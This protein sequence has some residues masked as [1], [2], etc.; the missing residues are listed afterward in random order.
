MR[1]RKGTNVLIDAFNELSKTNDN[2]E[3]YLVGSIDKV[4]KKY[5]V[6]NQNECIKIM[7]HVDQSTL[8]KYYQKCDIFVLPSFTEGLAM[9]QVQALACGLPIIISRFTGGDDLLEGYKKLGYKKPGYVIEEVSKEKIK[10]AILKYYTNLDLLSHHSKIASSLSKKNLSWEDYG[11][12][13]AENIKRT[14]K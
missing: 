2:L 10:E 14:L 6:K 8:H 5:L 3:L 12:R 11:K 13:Y 4:V 9:V 1:L 7:G